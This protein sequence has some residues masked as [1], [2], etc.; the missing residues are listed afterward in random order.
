MRIAR[1]VKCA[2][3]GTILKVTYDSRKDV[4]DRSV[5]TCGKLECYMN[6]QATIRYNSDGALMN[7]EKDKR[8]YQCEYY[9]EDFVALDAESNRLLDEI[10]S[11]VND[12]ITAHTAEQG[13]NMG[14]RFHDSS[15]KDCL[16]LELSDRTGDEEM[17]LNVD[18]DLVKGC[19]WKDEERIRLQERIHEALRRFRNVIEKMRSKDVG[20]GDPR[21]LWN[22]DSLNWEDAVRTQQQ[23]YDY[24]FYC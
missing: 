11:S 23:L 19:G 13:W 7:L 18:I 24:K 15:D 21:K 3:C 1:N 2:D 8:E 4:Q 5:C 9:D 16:R 22:D 14:L 10:R 12:L 6:S 20:T 17:S